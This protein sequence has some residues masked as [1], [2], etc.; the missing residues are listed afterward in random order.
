[1]RLKRS[2]GIPNSHVSVA[3]SSSVPG[4]MIDRFGNVVVR[5]VDL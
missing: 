3:A 4:A 2:S 1:M 5:K